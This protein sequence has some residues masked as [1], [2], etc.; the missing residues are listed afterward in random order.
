MVD[1]NTKKLVTIDMKC[2][3]GNSAWI[4]TPSQQRTFRTYISLTD[5]F[6]SQQFPVVCTMRWRTSTFMVMMYWLRMFLFI[7]ATCGM[8]Q[9]LT[10]NLPKADQIT[11]L[12][13]RSQ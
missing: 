7:V 3:L 4:G 2:M 8:T 10:I 11:R 13:I 5:G 6:M 9:D 12:E 1:I